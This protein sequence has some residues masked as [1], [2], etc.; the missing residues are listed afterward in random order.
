MPAL[1]Q[2]MARFS[3]RLAGP[4]VTDTLLESP[5]L[6]QL[7]RKFCDG[8]VS[9]LASLRELAGRQAWDELAAAAHRL[10]GAGG[11]YGF[12]AIT[13]DAKALERAARGG[14]AE[15]IHTALEALAQTCA[16]AR[17]RVD[18]APAPGG[19]P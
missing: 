18:Q 6:R 15:E 14:G 19:R 5:A 11:A 8:I 17:A 16:A 10:A 2:T 1:L 12:D 3:G 7:T 9:I 4:S 13:R